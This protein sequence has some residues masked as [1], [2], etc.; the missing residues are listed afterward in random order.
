MCEARNS[1]ARD[2]CATELP[3][4]RTDEVRSETV[5]LRCNRFARKSV[6]QNVTG[7]MTD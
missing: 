2:R 7:L 4:P 1:I 6:S 3:A 5:M